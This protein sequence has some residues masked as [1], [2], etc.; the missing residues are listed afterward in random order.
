MK[1]IK[2]VKPMFNRVITT[3][4][5]YETDQYK[6]NMLD[7]TKQ[8]G[9]IKEYQ[10]VVAVGTTVRDIKAGD[11]VIIDPTRYMIVKHNDKSIKK[12]IVGDELNVGYD[13]P[14]M[15]LDGKEHLLLF[16]QD[17]S[18]IIEDSEEVEDPAESKIIKP[19][20]PS[21]II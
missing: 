13:I 11:E 4:D 5:V 7:I 9:T 6:G 18:Y 19:E 1:V 10:T 17:I 14:T 21:I 15:K 16:D 2:K 8:K 20:K 3:M 12:N